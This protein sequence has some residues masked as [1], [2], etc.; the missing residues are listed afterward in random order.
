MLQ[1]N[2]ER[3]WAAIWGRGLVGKLCISLPV[4]HPRMG[5]LIGR[6]APG[7]RSA[8]QGTARDEKWARMK[9]R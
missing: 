5:A 6:G 4:R 2:C 8:R 9:V 1:D 3:R 7:A